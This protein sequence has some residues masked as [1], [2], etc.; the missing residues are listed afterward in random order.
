MEFFLIFEFVPLI[1]AIGEEVV[2]VL[3]HIVASVEEVLKIVKTYAIKVETFLRNCRYGECEH[4]CQDEQMSFHITLILVSNSVVFP[5]S[6][7][8]RELR[9]C[10][11]RKNNR[12]KRTFVQKN[13]G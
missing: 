4:S 6:C 13:L 9:F 3:P 10:K 7:V 12:L 11:Y 8:R 1:R 5:A 2:V